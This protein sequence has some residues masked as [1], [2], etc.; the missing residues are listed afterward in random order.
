MPDGPRRS[1][2]EPAEAPAR[3]LADGLRAAVRDRALRRPAGERDE[4]EQ[5]A[6]DGAEA[7]AR[8]DDAGELGQPRA[9]D[10]LAVGERDPRARAAP[11]SASAPACRRPGSRP[12][13]RSSRSGARRT[14]SARRRPR[15]AQHGQARRRGRRASSPSRC[16]SDLRDS[17]TGKRR[18]RR[19]RRR[20]RVSSTYGRLVRLGHARRSGPARATPRAAASSSGSPI[21]TSAAAPRRA[22]A[23]A[24][25]RRLA[26]RAQLAREQRHERPRAVDDDRPPVGAR[27]RATRG[28]SPSSAPGPSAGLPLTRASAG[29]GR[30]SPAGS[31]SRPGWR[32]STSRRSETNGSGMPVIGATPIVMPTLTNTWNTNAKTSPPATI[33]LYRS[34]RAG[35]DLQAAPDDEQVE[36]Q[37]DRG[38]EEAALLGERGEREVGRVLGQVVE[39]RLRRAGD[40]APAHSRRRRPR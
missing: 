14:G 2:S 30:G 11:G 29:R 38:A 16:A 10:R 36:Q 31:R 9:V 18:A 3:G 28:R 12:P 15:L 34:R 19:A 6:R 40:A 25:G 21:Q 35:D 17:S 33:A 13:R 4:L 23:L 1:G 8:A 37:Q 32:S 27:A 7:E 26:A 24:H 20:G 22:A 39:A 5:L